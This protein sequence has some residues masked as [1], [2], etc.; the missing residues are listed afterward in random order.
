MWTLVYKS[1]ENSRYNPHSSTQ[2]WNVVL[3][4]TNWTLT[5]TGAPP[6]IDILGIIIN[7][8]QSVV[9]LYSYVGEF[10]VIFILIMKMNWDNSHLLIII[11][12]ITLIEPMGHDVIALR[13]G[14]LGA[15]RRKLDRLHGVRASSLEQRRHGIWLLRN[16]DIYDNNIIYIY[17]YIISISYCVYIYIYM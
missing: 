13:H 1:H 11:L 17:T 8:S 15:V 6:C 10:P 7:Y 16:Q 2:T 4:C 12:H 5:I 9:Y 14:Q 3:M